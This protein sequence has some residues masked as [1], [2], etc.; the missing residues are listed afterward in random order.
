AAAPRT[1]ED[2]AIGPAS[3]PELAVVECD[4]GR[5]RTREPGHGPGVH[6]AAE[7]WRESK[8]AVLIR[9]TRNAS[10]HDP[11]PEP[12]ACFC[13]SEHVAKMV[14]AEALSVASS[15]LLLSQETQR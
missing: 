11:Q 14:E 7:G 2:L 10:D 4:G 3:P 12:P 15:S 5:I 1:D 8:N 13:D 6:R 9:A